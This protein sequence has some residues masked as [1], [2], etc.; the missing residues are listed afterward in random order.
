MDIG[1]QKTLGGFKQRLTEQH[2]GIKTESFFVLSGTW[3]QRGKFCS[4]TGVWTVNHLQKTGARGGRPEDRDRQ[5]TSADSSA[6]TGSLS[7]QYPANSEQA[8]NA[9]QRRVKERN[10]RLICLGLLC[11]L[12]DMPAAAAVSESRCSTD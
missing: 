8:E 9:A 12:R 4:S 5:R 11:F 7:L 10:L 6:S 2:T 1:D 3:T